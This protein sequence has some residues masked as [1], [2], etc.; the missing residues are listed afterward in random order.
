MPTPPPPP[1]YY[2]ETLKFNKQWKVRVA[3]DS[4]VRGLVGVGVGFDRLLAG[5]AWGGGAK[6]PPNA[7]RAL[8]RGR[9]RRRW[10]G[11]MVARLA[12]ALRDRLA[13]CLATH[14][15]LRRRPTHRPEPQPR[16][17]PRLQ[18]GRALGQKLQAAAH[19]GEWAR[20]R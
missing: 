3:G 8:I 1:A 15:P 9:G 2:V 20:R 7:P 16:L 18:A 13:G 10:Q 4:Q 12:A 6:A 17:L 11:G 5:V 19:A 14:A